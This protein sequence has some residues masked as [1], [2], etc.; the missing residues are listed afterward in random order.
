MGGQGVHRR[1]VQ[2]VTRIEERDKDRGVE[3][4]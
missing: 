2:P 1:L 4:D 3:D